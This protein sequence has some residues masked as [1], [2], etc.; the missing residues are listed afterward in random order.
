MFVK[1]CQGSIRAHLVLPKLKLKACVAMHSFLHGFQ[2]Q[3]F[4]AYVT[5]TLST[6][7]SP[8]PYFLKNE[9]ARPVVIG[10]FLFDILLLVVT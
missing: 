1:E 3:A 8:S 10:L 6:E 5:A 4:G 2:N 7:L 9:N